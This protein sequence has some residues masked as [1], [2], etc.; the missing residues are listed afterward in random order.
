MTAAADRVTAGFHA[1]T[2]REIRRETEDSVSIAFAVPDRLAATFRFAPGQYLTL[3]CFLDGAE[4][5]RPYSICAGLDDGELRIAVRLLEGGRFSGFVR[6]RLRA[7]E[8]LEV[9][10][11]MGRFT[12]P[13][14]PEAAR[15]FLAIAAGSGIT[16][17]LSLL[18]TILAREPKSRFVL[19][20]G[21]RTA[22]SIMFR[23]ALQD[24]KDRH[25]DRLTVLHVLSREPQPVP[26]LSG[27][28][29]RERI[30]A[31][32]AHVLP[33]AMI[34][35]ALLCGSSGLIETA[36]ATLLVA[37][38]PPERVHA[39]LF[40]P[41][42]DAGPPA[43][44]PPAPGRDRAALALVVLGGRRHELELMA[45]ETVVAAAR[46]VGL[47]VPYSCTGGMCCTC[48]AKLLAGEV[49]MAVNYG[50]EPAELEAG[51]VLAC[52]ARPRTARLVLDFDTR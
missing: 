44:A 1:L 5:R 41:A 17:V 51:F 42:A 6:E 19:L 47:D 3:R 22:R 4:L 49:T 18:K 20:Y 14:A 27:R 16:P 35:H 10:P 48:R 33:A 15:G 2:V 9:M 11:P 46:R 24:L 43:A 13:L 30:A 21:N 52:Q 31:V 39:E 32:L 50:L 12:V 38:L 45:G 7:G 26:L 40:T 23:D 36:R 28:I 25:L 34:D 37:G 8:R 29:D